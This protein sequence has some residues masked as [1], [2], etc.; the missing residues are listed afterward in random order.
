MR[1][2]R[3]VCKKKK[4]SQQKKPQC[5]HLFKDV[6]KNLILTDVPLLG[7]CCSTELFQICQLVLLPDLELNLEDLIKKCEVL[8]SHMFLL[9]LFHLVLLNLFQG[10]LCASIILDICILNLPLTTDNSFFFFFFL[11]SVLITKYKVKQLTPQQQLFCSRNPKNCSML[12][13]QGQTIT[14]FFPRLTLE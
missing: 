12:S 13:V 6:F 8:T 4:K 10:F 2:G 1:A 11:F 7:Y 14:E 3:F 5:F 9:R